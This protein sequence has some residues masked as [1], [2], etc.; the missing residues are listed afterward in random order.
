VFHIAISGEYVGF[1][2]LADVL[3]PEAKMV[4]SELMKMGIE[5]WMVSGDNQVLNKNTQAFI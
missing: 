2:A 5:V 4:V 3:K 1:V